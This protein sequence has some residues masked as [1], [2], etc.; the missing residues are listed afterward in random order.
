MQIARRV[1]RSAPISKATESIYDYFAPFVERATPHRP[2]KMPISK[3]AIKTATIAYDKNPDAVPE[4]FTEGFPLG[5]AKIQRREMV[6][7][8]MRK[9]VDAHFPRIAQYMR[10]QYD[11]MIVHVDGDSSSRGYRII[12]PGEDPAAVE[13]FAQW[14]ERHE[15]G[16]H[17]AADDTLDE[18]N[19]LRPDA[20]THRTKL[21]TKK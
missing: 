12:L 5:F 4:R 8:R 7:E 2:P 1:G 10:E 19:R 13:A 16:A 14:Y 17:E 18:V 6:I 20:I 3:I 11:V 15:R 21:I 9:F